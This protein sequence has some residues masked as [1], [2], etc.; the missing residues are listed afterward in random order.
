MKG[1]FTALAILLLVSCKESSVQLAKPST[2]VRYFNGGYSDQAQNVIETSDKGFLILANTLISQYQIKLIKTD[3][4]G[5][6][7]WMKIY[8]DATGKAG[9]R[10][11]GLAAIQDANGNDSGYLIAGDSING[12]TS[13]LML[14][15][16][17][18]NG[19][20][21]TNSPMIKKGLNYQGVGVA[22][23]KTKGDFFVVGQI[24]ADAPASSLN[25][26]SM[27]FA[28]VDH[29]NLQHIVFSKKF[30]N[31][32]GT[33]A[34]RLY[35]DYSEQSAF[36]GGSVTYSNTGTPVTLGRFDKSGS[37]FNSQ[38][39]GF[40]LTI[41]NSTAYA[42]PGYSST[43]SDLSPYGFGYVFVGSRSANGTNNYD[44]ILTARLSPDGTALDTV[45]SFKLINSTN[46]TNSTVA[47]TV[48]P[49]NSI[50][51]TQ[52]GGLLILGTIFVDQAGTNTDY[53]L[54][55][56]DAFG[57]QQWKNQ[58]GGKYIDTGVKVLQASDGGYI[59]L[60]TTTLANVPTILLMKTDLEGNI[61]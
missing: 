49:G 56:V 34:N 4:F 15:Q 58:Q 23:S 52:D 61:Q 36:W 19:T 35:L 18:Q 2:F 22:W 14:I 33:L 60:G 5:N 3:A 55:K 43:Y 13:S 1:I 8:N 26:S 40:D 38:I 53:Y 24:S 37:G 21:A 47:Q 32:T 39:V 54:I 59:V 20:Q 10:G 27:L 45:S 31:G 50:C 51:S 9:Y 11:F 17:D 29:T 16:V 41:G 42:S 48:L 25:D 12:T 7:V 30:G 46:K 57:K 28:Q 6:Q 44:R